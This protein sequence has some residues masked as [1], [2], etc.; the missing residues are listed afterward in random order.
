MSNRP[1]IRLRRRCHGSRLGGAHTVEHR[2]CT[3]AIGQNNPQPMLGETRKALVEVECFLTVRRDPPQRRRDRPFSP[4]PTDALR[5]LKACNRK[6]RSFSPPLDLFFLHHGSISTA[7]NSTSGKGNLPRC[8]ASISAG[9]AWPWSPDCC[10]GEGQGGRS[11]RR[12]ASSPAT[13]RPPTLSTRLCLSRARHVQA[14]EGRGEGLIG[15]RPAPLR[16][17]LTRH[18]GFAARPCSRSAGRYSHGRLACWVRVRS[19]W[20]DCACWPPS[21]SATSRRSMQAKSAKN[22]PMGT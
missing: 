16:S 12:A 21:T 2:F 20:A 11:R 1:R 18:P 9:P 14:G 4:L 8:L 15:A 22:A 17:S 3:L 10:A 13:G 7:E 5:L 6:S 19:A